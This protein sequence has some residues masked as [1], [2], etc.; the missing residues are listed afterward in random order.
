MYNTLNYDSLHINE[1]INNVHCIVDMS[2]LSDHEYVDVISL[3]LWQTDAVFFKV[4]ICF[5]II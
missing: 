1:A 2:Y 3:V 4:P 5:Y